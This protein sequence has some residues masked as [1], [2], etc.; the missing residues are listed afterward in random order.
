MAYSRRD[1]TGAAPATTLASGITSGDTTI[2]LASGTGYPTGTNGDF[3][4]VIDRGNSSEEKI[5]IA[6]RAGTSL[7]VQTSGR[8]SDG[9]T[10][11]AHS[12]GATVELTLTAVDLDEANYAVSKT[13]GKVAAAGDLLYGDAA[14]SLAKLAKGT[15]GQ[16]LKQGVT[17]PSWATVASTDVS[18]FTEAVQDVVGAYTAGGTNITVTYN[19]AANTLT[20]AQTN[21]TSTGITDFTEAVQDVVGA[22]GWGGSGLTFTYNDAA[23]TAVIDLNVDGSTVEVNADTLRVKDAGI[24]T[25]KIADSAVTT[26][27]IADAGITLAKMAATVR[28]ITLSA[29]TPASPTAGDFWWDS[30]NYGLK[31][32]TS[33][34]TGFRAPWNMPW[35]YI[36]LGESTSDT[37]SS[38]VYSLAVSVSVPQVAGRRY[39][40]TLIGHQYGS[41]AGD[42]MSISLTDGAGAVIN[43]S[44]FDC[45]TDGV[46][47]ARAFTFVG[48]EA[49]TSTATVTRAMAIGRT[50]GSGTE[51]LFADAD[52]KARLIVEDIGPSA[53]PA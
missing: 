24:V 48:Y 52:R 22:L 30:T 23:N 20:I 32:Y 1:F 17:T 10:A 28:P 44:R 12:A 36:I 35:G 37:T 50:S 31:E 34:T 13:V 21:A 16:F 29:T 11:V 25:A 6:S 53:N 14:N 2:T 15:S 45:T 9:T 47:F 38:G 49:A 51:H 42:T 40:Y 39:R 41:V 5:R 8:G 46:V 18:D 4:V 27:K 7:T 19:D 3:F 33:A 26:A 43:G